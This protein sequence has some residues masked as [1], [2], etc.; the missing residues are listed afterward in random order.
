VAETNQFQRRLQQIG[1]GLT[2]LESVADPAVRATSKET[3][4]LLMEM[5]GAALNRMLEILFQLG[6]NGARMIDELG[7]DPEV[8]SLLVLYG[9]HPE[10]LETRVEHKLIDVRSRLFKM[11][12]E[13][14]LVSVSGSEVRVHVTLQGH[15]CGSTAQNVRTLVEEA[16]YEAAPELTSLVVEGLDDPKPSGFVAMESLVGSTMARDT[17]RGVSVPSSSDGQG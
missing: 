17:V 14:K 1:D 9:L 5:H 15:S 7:Q 4:Q 8:S 13:A 11:G 10:D 16:M 3:I 6:E 2:K 12:A